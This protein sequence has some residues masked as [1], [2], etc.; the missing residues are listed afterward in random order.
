MRRRDLSSSQKD[1][2][3]NTHFTRTFPNSPPYG[4]T[5]NDNHLVKTNSYQKHFHIE[6]NASVNEFK[7]INLKHHARY[8][9][10]VEACREGEG[11]NCD[12]GIVA[13]QRTGSK[14]QADDVVN[15]TLEKLPTS[16]NRMNVRVS[17]HEPSEPNGFIVS[18]NILFFRNGIEY[19]IN[20]EL[21]ITPNMYRS[22]NGS[23]TIANLPNVNH[24]FKIR[25]S[26]KH[27]SK[28][29]FLLKEVE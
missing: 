8:A 14:T 2:S 19:G 20:Q 1:L 6:V 27:W 23:H 16:N 18:Y 5:P 9:I 7:L 15:V 24:T 12:D 11:E 22:N 13:Y 28:P 26:E 25:A 3:A 4:D 10:S 17:W 29:A 21:C